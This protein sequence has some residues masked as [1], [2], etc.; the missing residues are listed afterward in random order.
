LHDALPISYYLI[1]SGATGWDPNPAQYATATEILGEWT[2]HGNPVSGD[3]AGTTH[4]SQSTCVIPVD[5]EQGTYIYMGDRWTPSDL[6]NAPYVWLP[7]RCGEGTETSLPRRGRARRDAPAAPHRHPP[8][9]GREHLHPEDQLGGSARPARA[10]R[11]HRL[12]LG[13][14]GADRDPPGA[15]RSP[16]HGARG[17]RRGRGD[18]RLP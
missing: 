1:T 2:D 16:P 13:E 3:G 12:P 4:G 6:A 14:R 5:P 7:L 17:Q 18:E 8:P 15:R 11:G 9:R 10:R